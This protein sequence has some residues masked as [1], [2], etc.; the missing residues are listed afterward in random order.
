MGKVHDTLMTY[1]ANYRLFC[2][3]IF[4]CILY[5]NRDT[6][7]KGYDSY[8][9]YYQIYFHPDV[10]EHVRAFGTPF[11]KFNHQNLWPTFENDDNFRDE[12][13]SPS[14]WLKLN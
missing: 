5:R 14:V 1:S 4:N 6:S 8:Q 7:R 9:K 2:M 10:S 13:D 11:I 3:S 12:M